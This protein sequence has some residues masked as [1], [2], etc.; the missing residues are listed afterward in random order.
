MATEVETD[1]CFL[2]LGNVVHKFSEV[3]LDC[4]CNLVLL[5]PQ[6]GQSL[7]FPVPADYD[8]TVIFDA[9]RHRLLSSVIPGKED[10]CSFP[11]MGWS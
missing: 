10:W 6:I 3:D 11:D 4:I 9:S 7:T 8:R 1:Q 2:S 5:H